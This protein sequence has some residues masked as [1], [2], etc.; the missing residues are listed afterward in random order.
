[1]LWL[2]LN[3]SDV[4]PPAESYKRQFDSRLSPPLATYYVF[5]LHHNTATFVIL[6]Y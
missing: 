4:K 2:P 6:S 1:M 3:A 5:Q